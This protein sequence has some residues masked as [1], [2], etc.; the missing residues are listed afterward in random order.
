[1]VRGT[2]S[3]WLAPTQDIYQRLR[4]GWAR[5]GRRR[6][7]RRARGGGAGLETEQ[8]LA[9]VLLIPLDRR[10]KLE[11]PTQSLNQEGSRLT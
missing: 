5:W 11:N 9:T 2:G 10:G 7:G 1:M 6:G 8:V 3:V 4:A